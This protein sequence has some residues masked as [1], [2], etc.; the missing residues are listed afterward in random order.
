MDIFLK[1]IKIYILSKMKCF[2]LLYFILFEF[3]LAAQNTVWDNTINT[4]WPE[5]FTKVNIR[6]Y[7]SRK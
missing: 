7:T 2:I 4:N 6:Y 3:M 1:Q 5:N